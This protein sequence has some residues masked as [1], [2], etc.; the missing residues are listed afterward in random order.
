MGAKGLV[1]NVS[2]GIVKHSP[3]ILTGLGIAGGVTTVVLAVR[4]TPK[5]MYLLD[6]AREAKR[7]MP[8]PEDAEIEDDVTLTVGETVKAAWKCYIPAAVSGAVSIGCII[9]GQTVNSKRNAAIAAAYGVAETA[10]TEYQ[11]KVIEKIGT[12]KETE[13][14]DAIAQD[15]V[16]ENPVSKNDIIITGK[17][18]MLCYDDVG[19]RYFE[20][21]VESIRKV[22][23]DL[24]AEMIQEN[25][26]SLNDF[27]YAIGLSSTSLG[28]DMGWNISDG[29]IDVVFSGSISDD[30]RPC[31]VI[32]YRVMPRFDFRNLY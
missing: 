13:I 28:N 7:I 20:S 8:L 15:H 4:A 24:N 23:N 29:L 9:A 3:A 18:E 10:L 22:I 19:G 16:K 32:S 31:I 1:A 21:D 27:Y 6:Q 2:H 30:G 14:R 25:Y 17:G 5:A 12:K 11:T 26:I